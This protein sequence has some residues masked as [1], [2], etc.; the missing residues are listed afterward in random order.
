MNAKH[1]LEVKSDEE[2]HMY[3]VLYTARDNFLSSEG[4]G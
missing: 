1:G 3:K 4:K 2:N